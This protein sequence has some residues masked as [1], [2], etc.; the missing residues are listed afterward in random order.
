[1]GDQPMESFTVRVSKDYLVFCCAHFITY[2]G[3]TCERLH[4]HNYRAT[5]EVEGPLDE[6]QYVF[7]FIALKN[8]M[9]RITDELDHHVLLP[10][11]SKLI[12]VEANDRQVIVCFGTREWVFPREDCVLLPI[13]NTTAELL[14]RW[15]AERLTEA[16]VRERKFRPTRVRIE[17]EE[18][19]GQLATY[20]LKSDSGA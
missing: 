10:T 20:E 13:S 18:S 12:R 11:T 5:A 2:D 9:R 15:I 4:G 14:A 16:L 6:N 3:N 19:F 1:M 17:V 8:L 7:D